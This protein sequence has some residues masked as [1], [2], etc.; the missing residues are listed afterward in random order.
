MSNESS[1][2]PRGQLSRQW[3]T[4]WQLSRLIGD[5]HSSRDCRDKRKDS[6][7]NNVP[8]TNLL[9]IVKNNLILWWEMGNY[10]LCMTHWPRHWWPALTQCYKYYSPASPLV[11]SS[12]V[13]VMMMVVVAEAASPDVMVMMVVVKTSSP[14]AAMVVAPSNMTSAVRHCFCQISW[15][16][17]DLLYW[18]L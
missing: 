1:G 17:V 12:V 8:G 13:A 14:S 6:S 7:F 4:K 11:P 18:V 10:K 5:N 15:D 2:T 3:R 9:V 16:R